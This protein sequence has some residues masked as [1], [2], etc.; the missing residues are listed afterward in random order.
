MPRVVMTHSVE[1]VERW[2]AG[3]Q[4]RAAGASAFGSDVTDYV[5]MDGSN[6]V[7]VTMDVQDMAA[8]QAM[9]ASPDAEMAAAA[10]RHGVIPPIT[11]YVE[12]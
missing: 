4:E 8:A 12:Q 1:D 3:K 7:A 6:N 9:L 5:A 2:L 10:L 11:V